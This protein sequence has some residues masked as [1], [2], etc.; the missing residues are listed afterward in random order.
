M[1]LFTQSSNTYFRGASTETQALCLHSVLTAG[2][3][4]YGLMLVSNNPWYQI[5]PSPRDND[6]TGWS[7]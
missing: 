6:G 3:Y 4:L 7:I 1:R 5:I 2:Y